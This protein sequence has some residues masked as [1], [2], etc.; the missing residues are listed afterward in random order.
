VE[1]SVFDN[2]VTD[3]CQRDRRPACAVQCPFGLDVRDFIAKSVRGNF[4]AAL[5]IY[6]NAVVFP[7]IVSALCPGYCQAACPLRRNDGAIRLD[8]LEKA[9]LA[10]ARDSRPLQYN[11]P[12]KPERVAVIGGGPAGLACALK[13]AAKRYQVAL[14]ERE[15]RPGGSLWRLL[16]EPV[17]RDELE[18][19]VDGIGDR[20]FLGRD[21]RAL[22]GVEAE[23]VF[24]ATGD[25]GR[26]FGLLGAVDRITLATARPGVFLGGGLLAKDVLHA[27]AQGIRA[28]ASIERFLKTGA[29]P[30][31]DAF[32]AGEG[33]C[34]AAETAPAS[35][36]CVAARQTAFTREEAMAEAGRCLLCNCSSCMDNCAFL[37]Y[38][39]RYPRNIVDA[40]DYGLTDQA[41]EPQS[42]NRMVNSCSN[43]GNCGQCC[44]EHIDLGGALLAAKRQM[45][46]RGQIPP[47]YHDYWLQDL[48][49]AL[50]G[51]AY[52]AL[53]S[54][55]SE[56]E[57]D[58]RLAFFPGCQ[59][60]ASA[61][62]YG[63]TAYGLLLAQE[64]RTG[65]INGCCGAPALWAGDSALHEQ[66]LGRLLADW[67]K[68]GGPPLVLAC[69][70]C[71]KLL[72]EYA[73]SV[74][75]VSLYELL[76]KGAGS[77]L[78][79]QSLKGACLFD[80]CSARY[81]P[82]AQTAVRSL[83]DKS[84][85]SYKPLSQVGGVSP[86]CG[87]GG[88]I[89]VA[90]PGLAGEKAAQCASYGEGP[91]ITYCANCRDILAAQGR[92]AYHLLDILGNG[93]LPPPR[94]APTVS[95]R[96]NNRRHAQKQWLEKFWGQTV[97]MPKPE[98][99]A[100][101]IVSPALRE[102]LSGDWLL[103][104]DVQTVIEQAE[105]TGQIIFD[106]QDNLYIAHQRLSLLTYWVKYR[107]VSGGYELADVYAHRLR[108]K[109]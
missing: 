84:A 21:I 79:R 46:R 31:A 23:A 86:C 83:L 68:L 105:K 5:R 1:Q 13:L 89:A 48:A 65:L 73:P 12:E 91:Y 103:E 56:R 99:T 100:K 4:D 78:P 7:G 67:K 36:A 29:A 107:R 70:T 8:L 98:D 45:F 66:V 43:C 94:P 54:P 35:L 92:P 15:A 51:Q 76:D 42:N 11:L 49:F 74:R 17:I 82:A 44:P 3:P 96:R 20:L 2:T 58:N 87:F 81:S 34:L 30:E 39:R 41:V 25:G 52:L 27:L 33:S 37:R 88:H 53:P 90:N 26:D 6:R 64:P 93:L 106:S 22:E 32:A 18:R 69:P 47:V 16:P 24:I 55:C 40:V 72:R 62:A 71:M 38:Y 19:E 108:I 50:S 109:Q 75:Q 14:Y 61:P 57:D 60:A 97:M 59:L 9:A 77:G 10:Q 104:E 63:E 80:P 102:K 95:E 28:A 101:L 85:V